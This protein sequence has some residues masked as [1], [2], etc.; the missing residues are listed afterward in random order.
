MQRRNCA[1]AAMKFPGPLWLCRLSNSLATLKRLRATQRGSFPF[2]FFS[3]FFFFS[4]S[5]EQAVA[6]VTS[7]VTGHDHDGQ[8]K[9]KKTLAHLAGLAFWLMDVQC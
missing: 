3:L 6:R 7:C 5:T 8:A 9:A 4:L 1:G 2:P